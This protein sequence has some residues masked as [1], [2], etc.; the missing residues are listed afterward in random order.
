MGAR[1]LT[2]SLVGIATDLD[3]GAILVL[4]DG[5]INIKAPEGS[6]PLPRR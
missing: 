5:H 1:R 2:E 4:E 3:T 6:R